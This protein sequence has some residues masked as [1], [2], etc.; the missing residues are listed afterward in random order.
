MTYAFCECLGVLRPAEA[1]RT[2]T[3][4][5]ALAVVGLRRMT[6]VCF[7][8]GRLLGSLSGEKIVRVPGDGQRIN[9]LRDDMMSCGCVTGQQCPRR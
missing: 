4:E 9:E 5:I 7:A 1:V 6:D 8:L 3:K 2:L